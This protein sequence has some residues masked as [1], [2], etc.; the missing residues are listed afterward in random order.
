[1]T[2]I[3]TPSI[4]MYGLDALVARYEQSWPDISNR[5]HLTHDDF[6]SLFQFIVLNAFND[7]VKNAVDRPQ[8]TRY[9]RKAAEMYHCVYNEILND[10]QY[11]FHSLLPVSQEDFQRW[12]EVGYQAAVFNNILIVSPELTWT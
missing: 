9:R 5:Y 11:A 4:S 3:P 8:E 2:Y 7:R 10:D 1:M 12:F 6:Y